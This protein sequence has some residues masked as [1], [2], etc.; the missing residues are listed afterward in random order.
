MKNQVIPDTSGYPLRDDFKNEYSQEAK[1][2]LGSRSGSVIR[3]ALV[4]ILSIGVDF[5][6]LIQTMFMISLKANTRS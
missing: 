6:F 4:L 3:W 5:H 2:I 1:E